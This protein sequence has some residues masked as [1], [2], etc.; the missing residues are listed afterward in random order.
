MILQMYFIV[1]KNEGHIAY[2]LTR[3]MFTY[4]STE[5]CFPIDFF[6]SVSQYY[7][8]CFYNHSSHCLVAFR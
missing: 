5:S 3:K 4:V 1:T 6:L 7:W 2:K 8:K